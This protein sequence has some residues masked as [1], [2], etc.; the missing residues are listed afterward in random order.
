MTGFSEG[1]EPKLAFQM[2]CDTNFI[3]PIE[4]KDSN[5]AVSLYFNECILK[6]LW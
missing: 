4:G 6:G 3:G 1:V 2:M 5:V